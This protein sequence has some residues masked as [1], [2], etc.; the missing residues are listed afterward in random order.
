[1]NVL[2]GHRGIDTAAIFME[3]RCIF[4]VT[5]TKDV[6]QVHSRNGSVSRIHF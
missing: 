3:G 5:G 2:G 1:M 6:C 4:A